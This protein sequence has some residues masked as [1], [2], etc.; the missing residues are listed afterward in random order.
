MAFLQCWKILK[1]VSIIK[2]TYIDCITDCFAAIAQSVSSA[3]TSSVTGATSSSTTATSSSSSTQGYCMCV[4][5]CCVC[6]CAHS[7]CSYTQAAPGL[8]KCSLRIHLC[9]S[10]SSV[11]CM[12]AKPLENMTR[13]L[14]YAKIA[15]GTNE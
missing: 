8:K 6:V 14:K 10:A 13:L 9:A 4:F 3:A 2:K 7:E 15:H 1:K 12:L 5:V 11:L